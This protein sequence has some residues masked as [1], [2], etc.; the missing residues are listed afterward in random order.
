M[1]GGTFVTQNKV[2]PGVYINILS[3]PKSLGTVG[4][5]GIVSLPLSLSW[6]EA[7][8]V[9]TINAGDDVRGLLGYD[10]TD[11][12]VL[13]V[14]EALKRAKTLLL[15]RLNAGVKA[16]ATHVNLTLTAKYGGVRGNDIS[17][18]VETNI[19][20]N[21][22][23]DVKTLFAGEEVDLQTVADIA[24]LIDN[25]WVDFSGAGALTT[26]AGVPLTG[27]SDGAVT[28]QDHTDYRAA[29]ELYDFN[30]IGLPSNDATLKSVYSA[31]INRLREEEGRKV[32]VV[33]EN[34]PT[35]DYEGVIS[36]KNGAIL[37]DGTVIDSVKATA[38]VAGATAGAQVNQSLT[39]QAYDDAV[40]VDVRYTNAQIEA[41]LKN[42]ELVFVQNNGRAI[43]E[44]DINTCKSFT[45]TKGKHF[46]KNRVLRVLDGLAN[47]YKRIFETYYI[48]KVD[49]NPDGRN[50]FRK[51]CINQAELY[52]NINAI[53][54]FDSQNDIK[55]LPGQETDSIY[56]EV[57][58]QPV[59]SVEKVYMKVQVR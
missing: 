23:F 5:R 21:T 7:K 32:Q 39:Y 50:L 52:Q 20:D 33:L 17:L 35:A 22:K 28:N 44:Q 26:T 40:D 4:E 19:D 1:A 49:N 30:T 16:T 15:Y 34:Y 59:D 56:V 25:S 42:G 36:V 24:G 41:A 37:S 54:N 29:I 51:E 8:K 57:Y 43:V 47:D 58:A 45:P 6:G 10:I 53:Q 11:P 38:W 12:K 18:I 55:V 31:F 3:E 27:G 13:L 14:R 46:S 2:R 9:L 48:G